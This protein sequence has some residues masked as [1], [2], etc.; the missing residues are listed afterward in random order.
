MRSLED[1]LSR[2]AAY[3]RDPRNIVTH[4][5]GIPLVIAAVATLL[6]RPALDAGGVSV[7][8][9]LLVAAA[10]VAYYLKLD[11][12]L[13]AVMAFPL[14]LALIFGQWA[15]TL[16]TRDWLLVGFGAFV[17]G[18]MIQF[19]GHVW[20]GRKPAFLDDLIGLAI[21]PLFVLCELLFLLGLRPDL[22]LAIES[23]VG[24]ARR[25]ISTTHA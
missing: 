8:P 2:Y 3:H 17:I 4:F 14:L 18:W 7:T 19:V 24:P 21:G 23:R 12:I 6:G 11:F 25:R 10:A 20:E 5:I 1:A 16:P 15:A 9:A 22:K 13:G